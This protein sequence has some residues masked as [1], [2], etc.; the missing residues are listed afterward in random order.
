M[1]RVY[2]ITSQMC[3]VCVCI[4]EREEIAEMFMII[5]SG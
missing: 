3:R 5:I 4:R 2:I 1:K